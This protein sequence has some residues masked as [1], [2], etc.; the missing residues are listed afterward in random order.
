MGLIIIEEY[1]STGIDV[2]SYAQVHH[3]NKLNERT[4]NSSTTTSAASITLN[5]GTNLVRIYTDVAHRLAHE[6]ADTDNGANYTTT[7]AG[8]WISLGVKAGEPLYYRTDV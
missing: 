3:I 1:S 6:S 4:E 8:R 5:E 2:N 7:E